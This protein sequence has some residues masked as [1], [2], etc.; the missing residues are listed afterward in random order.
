MGYVTLQ[1]LSVFRL[2]GPLYTSIYSGG[3]G[4]SG[5][6]ASKSEHYGYI[7]TS[8]CLI[9]KQVLEAKALG[10]AMPAREHYGTRPDNE[11]MRRAAGP[12]IAAFLVHD[13][14]ASHLIKATSKLG[15]HSVPLQG[16]YIKLTC[17][18]CVNPELHACGARVC[19]RVR[20]S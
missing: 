16:F 10:E 19:I 6:K 4:I 17:R 18:A 3:H 12:E 5:I 14:A 20:A 2:I 13:P 7:Q 9:A 1:L 15:M 8:V 11:A